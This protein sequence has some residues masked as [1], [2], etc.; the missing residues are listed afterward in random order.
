MAKTIFDDDV[1][2]S[3][4]EISFS[5]KSQLIAHVD[6]H[7]TSYACSVAPDTSKYYP[8]PTRMLKIQ[9]KEYH[10]V[11]KIIEKSRFDEILAQNNTSAEKLTLEVWEDL[12]SDK[13]EWKK[14]SENYVEALSWQ[15]ELN[16]SVDGYSE[17]MAKEVS[18]TSYKMLNFE[19]NLTMRMN[20]LV[21]ENFF[22]SERSLKNDFTR[23]NGIKL[24]DF[25]F[26]SI[27]FVN[28]N[29]YITLLNEIVH[30]GKIKDSELLSWLDAC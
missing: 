18:H 20:E 19:R 8:T 17:I 25:I 16:N 10:V 28:E 1:D 22:N 2:F 3:E 11:E 6:Y 14:L 7:G 23:E 26:P 9:G 13:E 21:W 29:F 15:K 12:E 24:Y 30:K 4:I 5:D 27:M